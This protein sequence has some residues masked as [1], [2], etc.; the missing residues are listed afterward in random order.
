MHARACMARRHG[1]CAPY[2]LVVAARV[3]SPHKAVVALYGGV[4]VR[5]CAPRGHGGTLQQEAHVE[6]ERREDFAAAQAI[7]N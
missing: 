1:L 2:G 6:M 3:S 5:V 7:S 4:Y